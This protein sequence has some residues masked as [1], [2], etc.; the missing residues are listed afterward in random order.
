MVFTSDVLINQLIVAAWS[1]MA[2][3]LEVYLHSGQ[4]VPGLMSDVRCE[5]GLWGREQSLTHHTLVSITPYSGYCS[6]SPTTLISFLGE[7][8]EFV[9]LKFP[10]CTVALRKVPHPSYWVLLNSFKL[11]FTEIVLLAR[12]YQKR[13]PKSKF[14]T[15]T[16]ALLCL[17]SRAND[18]LWT[19]N[20][21]TWVDKRFFFSELWLFSH[22][23]PRKVIKMESHLLTH[24][25][26]HLLYWQE[27]GYMKWGWSPNTMNVSSALKK[28]KVWK[29]RTDYVT[30]RTVVIGIL[31]QGFFFFFFL[32]LS[33]SLMNSPYTFG[34]TFSATSITHLLP[35]RSFSQI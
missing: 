12:K 9:T 25:M 4:I 27:S 35:V 33:S 19:K 29:R 24:L 30:H 5:Q 18:G 22:E 23:K 1:M 13:D 26:N 15:L 28:K 21:Y 16:A 8:A 17:L 11:M 20:L 7:W 14:S 6:P 10:L 3:G 31:E 34:L 32:H 2:E